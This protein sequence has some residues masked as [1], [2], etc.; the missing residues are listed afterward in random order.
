MIDGNPV[1]FS[2]FNIGGYNFFGLRD[3]A[4]ALSGTASQFE[5]QWIEAFSAINLLRGR[6]YTPV[7]GEMAVWHVAYAVA[8]PTTAAVLLDGQSINL[9]AYNIGGFNF[10]M[11][12][13]LGSY[14]GFNV[15]WDGATNTILITTN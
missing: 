13:D 6:A 7:G 12:R 8:M 9:R 4:H 11:L 1:E 14:L 2:A 5:V 15:D 3:I 10:F